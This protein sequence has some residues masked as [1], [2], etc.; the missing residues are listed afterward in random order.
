MYC[1][2]GSSDFNRYI[3][4]LAL[5]NGTT[6]KKEIDDYHQRIQELFEKNKKIIIPDTD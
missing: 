3:N 6:R 4:D 1:A 2:E 5:K